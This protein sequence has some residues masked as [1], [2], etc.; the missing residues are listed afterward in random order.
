MCIVGC[1]SVGEECAKRFSAMG[2][3]VFGVDVFPREDNNYIRIFS[4]DSLNEVIARADVL[5][6]TLPL[7]EKTKHILG[8][9]ELSLL[10]E[11]SIIVNISRGGVLNTDALMEVMQRRQDMTAVLDV[12]E[13][14][15]LPCSSPLWDLSNVIISPHNSFVGEGNSLRLWERIIRNI[16][17]I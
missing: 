8:A 15:P 4:L 6:L 12:F 2:C 3:Q 9:D 11:C 16:K 17:N 13:D 1:G 14:E 10:P 7:T 5:I